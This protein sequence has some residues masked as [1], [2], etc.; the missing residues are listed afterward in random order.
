MKRICL[1]IVVLLLTAWVLPFPL[2]R[3]GAAETPTVNDI[4]AGLRRAEVVMSHA[5][6]LVDVDI[7]NPGSTAY[8]RSGRIERHGD[9]RR[10]TYAFQNRNLDT[11][12]MQDQDVTTVVTPEFAIVKLAKIGNPQLYRGEFLSRMMADNGLRNLRLDAWM[13][14][15]PYFYAVAGSGYSGSTAEQLLKAAASEKVEV[16]QGPSE[17]PSEW[18]EPADDET[19]LS[20]IWRADFKTEGSLD[21]TYRFLRQGDVW[22]VRRRQS[23]SVASIFGELSIDYAKVGPHAPL[24]ERIE[25]KDYRGRRITTT[26]TPV[27]REAWSFACGGTADTCHAKMT[28]DDAR[29]SPTDA[30]AVTETGETDPIP[31]GWAGGELVP[32]IEVFDSQLE[33]D[34]TPRQGAENGTQTA[35]APKEAPAPSAAPRDNSNPTR[36]AVGKPLLWSGLIFVTLV[37]AVVV[38]W[39][40]RRFA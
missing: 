15:D 34:P 26:V 3:A 4:V 14:E 20:I 10:T 18:P 25:T 9:Q 35:V 23:R 11:D 29:L 19:D 8:H 1:N 13:P 22:L 21:V 17:R 30:I 5:E 12:K 27:D 31:L 32:Y 33:P 39:I 36:F 6:L 24:V 2:G 37:V 38:V 40:F 7:Q 16:R 28:L